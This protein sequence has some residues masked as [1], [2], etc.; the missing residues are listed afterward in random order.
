VQDLKDDLLFI[1]Q[2]KVFLVEKNTFVI[3]IELTCAVRLPVPQGCTLAFLEHR[4]KSGSLC[5][6]YRRIRYF[7]SRGLGEIFVAPIDRN[8]EN[9]LSRQSWFKYQVLMQIFSPGNISLKTE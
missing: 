2:M 6:I 8:T 4:L 1:N 9:K 3:A 5:T 7:I